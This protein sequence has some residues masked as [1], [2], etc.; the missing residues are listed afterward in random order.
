MPDG[1]QDHG[2]NESTANAP[3]SIRRILIW[4]TGITAV[5]AALTGLIHG[6][7]KT[8]DALD[9]LAK[10]VATLWQSPP[11]PPCFSFDKQS[12]CVLCNFRIQKPGVSEHNGF[13]ETCTNMPP[14]TQITASFSGVVTTQ[15]RQNGDCTVQVDLALFGKNGASWKQQSS[16]CSFN[17]SIDSVSIQS[18]ADASPT[19]EVTLREC[20]SGGVFST[21]DFDGTL[22]ISATGSR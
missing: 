19:V 12:R 13:S 9:E 15:H 2:T 8:F 22:A 20:N 17:M 10:K 5:L 7:A 1:D 14:A 18:S 3:P 11:V 6:A 21:C 16:K 4:A